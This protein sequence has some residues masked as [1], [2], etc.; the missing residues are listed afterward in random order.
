MENIAG[1]S[2]VLLAFIATLGT[3]AVTALG[4]ALVFFFK[5]VK[6][7]VLN[8]MMGFAAGIMLAASYWS[9]LAPA[10]EHARGGPLPAWVVVAGGFVAGAGLL[11]VADVLMKAAPPRTQINPGPHESHR[12]SA[13][14]MLSITLHNIPEGAAIGVAFGAASLCAGDSLAGLLAAVSLAVGIG[15]Q[16]FPEGAAV[17]L[18]LRREGLSRRK[19]FLYG[20]AS[21]IVEPIAGVLGAALVMWVQPVLPWMLAFAAGAMVYV[22]AEELIPDANEPNPRGC[23]LGT[24]GTVAGFTIMMI[25][26]VALG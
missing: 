2:P 9:L 23:S 26:D 16:N 11:L 18:P 10:I 3:W 1:Y 7:G 22:V 8:M 14:L 5:K 19:S 4:A 21:G 17:S 12:R 20:Q 6:P 13:L 25:L 15:L 24:L